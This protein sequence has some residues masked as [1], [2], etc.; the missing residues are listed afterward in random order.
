MDVALVEYSQNDINRHQR[1]QNQPGLTG[2][3]A[4]ESSRS[5]LEA[6]M[7]AGR[8]TDGSPRIFDG[9][10]R[11]AQRDAKRKIERQGDRR[12]LCLVIQ[13]ERRVRGLVVGEGGQRD[14]HSGG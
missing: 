6:R 5:S 2:E 3:G 13:R 10:R 1:R 11:L 8:K 9:K 14:L 7:N 12:K 4:L